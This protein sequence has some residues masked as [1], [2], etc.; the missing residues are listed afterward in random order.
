MSA[1]LENMVQCA[2]WEDFREEVPGSKPG[3]SYVVCHGYQPPPSRY[4]YGF[5]CTCPS[6]RFAKGE[7]RTCKHIE[8]VKSHCCLWH[9]QFSEEQYKYDGKCPK[10]GDG[11][12]GVIVAV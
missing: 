6:F 3:T 12:K 7:D 5:S 1:Q 10:C 2:S 8:A 4:M 11:V 9:Q